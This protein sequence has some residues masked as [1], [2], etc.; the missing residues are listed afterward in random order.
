[1]EQPAREIDERDVA[2][3]REPRCDQEAEEWRRVAIETTG[4]PPRGDQRR[5]ERDAGENQSAE[6]HAIYCG[7]RCDAAT[8]SVG[9]APAAR[10]PRRGTART[11][12]G[13]FAT[14]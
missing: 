4:R 2:D 13:L 8:T 10:R 12:P 7:G 11:C 9:R 5:D 3:A 14:S 1:M 6:Q